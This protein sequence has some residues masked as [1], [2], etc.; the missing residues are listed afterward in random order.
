MNRWSVCKWCISSAAEKS[1]PTNTFSCCLFL[2]PFDR[3]QSDQ[4]F[5]GNYWA[6]YRNETVFL[7]SG[8][9]VSVSRRPMCLELKATGAAVILQERVRGRA[10]GV[11]E[12]WALCH[13]VFVGINCWGIPKSG[14][15]W[16]ASTTSITPP[17]SPSAAS[18][19]TSRWTCTPSSLLSQTTELPPPN[20]HLTPGPKPP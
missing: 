13:C 16:T 3:N 14:N 8:V 4:P 17:S 9:N 20:P 6:F 11:D 12:Y 5:W 19:R 18:T 7:R 10:E 15:T 2:V 1:S